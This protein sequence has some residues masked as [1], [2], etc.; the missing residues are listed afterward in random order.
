MKPYKLTEKEV[1]ILNTNKGLRAIFSKEP[2]NL[3]KM[4][5]PNGIF[6]VMSFNFQKL[7]KLF[8]ST[9]VGTTEPLLLRLMVFVRNK[10]MKFS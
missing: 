5:V 10:S 3:E 4:N 2:Y 6:N 8:F 7:E 1:E 9:E